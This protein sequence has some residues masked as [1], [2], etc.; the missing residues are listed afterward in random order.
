MVYKRVRVRPRSGA[1]SYKKIFEYPPRGGRALT[2]YGGIRERVWSHAFSLATL[3]SC[4]LGIFHEKEFSFSLL[5]QIINPYSV[6][7]E[8]T[9]VRLRKLYDLC[10]ASV[11]I[12]LDFVAVPKE[13]GQ[14]PTILTSRYSSKA[15]ISQQGNPNQPYCSTIHTN[16]ALVVSTLNFPSV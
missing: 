2:V 1:S 10:F 9:V 3:A 11:F 5:G 6:P 16:I 8:L 13:L 14:N 7:K 15:H 12:D 4:P